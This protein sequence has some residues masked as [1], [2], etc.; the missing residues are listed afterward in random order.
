MYHVCLTHL[1]VGPRAR[2]IGDA[3]LILN[4]NKKILR[5]KY[6]NIKTKIIKIFKNRRRYKSWNEY[7]LSKTE[8]IQIISEKKKI[9]DMI[10]SILKNL[11][12]GMKH[13]EQS[14]NTKKTYIHDMYNKEVLQIKK[15]I[16]SIIQKQSRNLN[17]RFK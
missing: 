7:F 2:Q 17:I 11:N 15:E 16:N 9:P 4:N 1:G 14:Q 10:I 8:N 13:H 12:H 6:L 3:Q 5:K